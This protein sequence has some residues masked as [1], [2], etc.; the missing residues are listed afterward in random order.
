MKK[1]ITLCLVAIIA[2]IAVIIAVVAIYRPGSLKETFTRRAQIDEPYFGYINLKQLATKGAFEQYFDENNRKMLA[3]MAS[4]EISDKAMADHAS[5]II[6]DFSA[7]GLNFEQP[8]YTYID[9]DNNQVIVIE[10]LDIAKVDKTMELVAY[11]YAESNDHTLQIQHDGDNRTTQIDNALLGYNTTRLAVAFNDSND[12]SDT[13]LIDA[14]ERPLADLSLFDDYDVAAYVHLGK[15]VDIARGELEAQK[16]EY[17]KLA[18]QDSANY[19]YDDQIASIDEMLVQINDIAQHV[20]E[21]SYGILSL[22]FDAGRATINAYTQNVDSLPTNGITKHVSNDHLRYVDISAPIVANIGLN[23]EKFVE[24]ADLILQSRYFTES[25]YNTND[26]NMVIAIV[27][28][29]FK[30]IDGDLTIAV[31]NLEGSYASYYGN[32][33]LRNVAASVMVDVKDNYII[34]NLGQFAGGF[35]RREDSTHFSGGFG[36]FNITL[37][38]DDNVFHAGINSPYTVR[39]E[40]ATDAEWFHNI[41]ESMGYMVVDVENLMACSYIAAANKALIN[42]LD[43]EYVDMYKKCVDVCNYIYLSQTEPAAYEFVIVFDNSEANALKQIT[44]I[45]MPHL[46]K[47][48]MAN[49]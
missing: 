13:I 34:S 49:M 24:V 40:A 17:L 15:V 44:D 18:E 14:L 22:T 41:N 43:S 19:Y 45:V 36:G 1:K 26:V 25:E 48:M 33:S 5:A 2:I 10:V 46:M 4:A 31:E 16:G 47:Q 20:N 23:G 42:D 11:L 28:D 7:S 30:S 35:L 6:T 39:G 38:Q 12:V 3:S 8:A 27:R 32:A 21:N 9:K 29:V 37:G